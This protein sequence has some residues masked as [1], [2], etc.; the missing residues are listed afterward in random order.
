MHSSPLLSKVAIQL[1]YKLLHSR[2]TIALCEKYVLGQFWDTKKLIQ[3][4]V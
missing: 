1:Q 4:L 3:N 2:C